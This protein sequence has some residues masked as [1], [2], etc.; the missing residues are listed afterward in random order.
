VLAAAQ[1]E[2][3]EETGFEP[4]NGPY[5]PLGEITYPEGAK[6]VTAWAAEG[7][8]DASKLLSVKF[9][10]QWPPRS[11]KKQHF[12]EVDKGGWFTLK[13]AAQ[14]LFAPN[15]P[16][17]KRLADELNAEFSEDEPGTTPKQNSLF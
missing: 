1:R 12:P 9:E 8:Y 15:E 13:D 7:D 4:P 16:F 14:K 3:K 11:G 6:T 10:M 17:L 2:F 5:I